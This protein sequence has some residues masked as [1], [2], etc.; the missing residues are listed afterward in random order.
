[1]QE[2]GTKAHQ[3]RLH[4]HR[5]IALVHNS[6]GDDG[7]SITTPAQTVLGDDEFAKLAASAIA[8]GT[9]L[10]LRGGVRVELQQRYKMVRAD[11]LRVVGGSFRGWGH[12][13]FEVGGNPR[14]LLELSGCELR[15]LPDETGRSERQKLGAAVFVRAKGRLSMIDCEVSSEKGFGLWL[16]QKASASLVGCRVGPC[17]RSSVCAF[18]DSRFVMEGSGIYGATPHGICA[19]G[20]AAIVA[21]R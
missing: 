5:G 3:R 1:M 11:V 18:E 8:T 10:D 2:K 17:G 7:S 4:Q 20:N 9:P 13:I 12:S 19:R 14:G 16:V 21:T 15:H 6:T